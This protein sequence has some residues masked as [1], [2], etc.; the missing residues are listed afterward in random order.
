M[1]RTTLPLLTL[2]VY[3]TLYFTQALTRRSNLF[4][5]PVFNKVYSYRTNY[6]SPISVNR[7]T[8][9]RM[10]TERTPR[11][12][13]NVI[14]NRVK[15]SH[16]VKEGKSDTIEMN[17]VVDQCLANTNFVVRIPN[18]ETFLCFIS[19]KLRINK[20]KINLGDMVKIQIHKLNFEKRRGKIVFRY[21]Q[22]AALGGKKW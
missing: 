3:V 1:Y 2:L 8:T 5:T 7:W 10:T 15:D 21:L 4:I 22:H 12:N 19:G 20:V 14:Y 18:G 11:R 9:W 16:V 13:V 6:G 17:G